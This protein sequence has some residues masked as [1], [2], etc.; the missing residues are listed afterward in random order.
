MNKE[1]LNL[2]EVVTIDKNKLLTTYRTANNEQKEILKQLYGEQMFID[3]RDITSYEKACEVLGIQPREFKEVGDRPHKY[4]PQT[5]EELRDIIEQRIEVE[6][7][8]VNLN[9]IDVSAITDMSA[10]FLWSDFNGD[11]TY[12]IGMYLM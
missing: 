11:K 1:N 6:G 8:E 12:L 2:V 10:L 4:F 5:K 3:W 9:D 7:N